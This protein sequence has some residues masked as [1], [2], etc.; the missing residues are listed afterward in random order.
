MPLWHCNVVCLA[1]STFPGV[2]AVL[3]GLS[4]L[5]SITVSIF[6]NQRPY[7]KNGFRNVYD[8]QPILKI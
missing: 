7:R 8:A 5:N 2:N 1:F 4:D 3:R 6:R